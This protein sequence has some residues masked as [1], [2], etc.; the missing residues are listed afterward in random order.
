MSPRRPGKSDKD[1]PHGRGIL[2]SLRRWA[3][4]AKAFPVQEESLAVSD[5]ILMAWQA[6]RETTESLAI[7]LSL[8]RSSIRKALSLARENLTR[9]AAGPGGPTEVVLVSNQLMSQSQGLLLVAQRVGDLAD[10]IYI[11]PL[12]SSSRLSPWWDLHWTRTSRLLGTSQGSAVFDDHYQDTGVIRFLT[13]QAH[14][15]EEMART[16]VEDLIRLFEGLGGRLLAPKDADLSTRL[17]LLPGKGE[18]G[19]ALVA[20]DLGTVADA[21]LAPLSKAIKENP[22]GARAAHK[23]ERWLE[24]GAARF[25]THLKTR[26]ATLLRRLKLKASAIDRQSA[27]LSARL[28]GVDGRISRYS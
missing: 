7:T 23:R 28:D 19:R 10:E 25:C 8:L 12:G 2:E 27:R 3:L 21:W 18:L 17:R 4:E 11:D 1:N 15:H 6:R 24:N 16:Q 26:Q 5:P 14:L 22:E 9:V 13:I 20:G